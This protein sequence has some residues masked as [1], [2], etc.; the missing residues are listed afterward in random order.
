ME[1]KLNSRVD[2]EVSGEIYHSLVE[3]IKE[4]EI[5]LSMIHR[6]QKP[7]DL[8]VGTELNVVYSVDEVAYKFSSQVLRE[9]FGGHVPLLFIT[10]P[11]RIERHQRR[12]WVRMRT[13]LT[14]HCAAARLLQPEE[15]AP[16]LTGKIHDLSGGG[17]L[18]EVGTACQAGDQLL[19]TIHLPDGEVKCL[20][21]VRRI[22][23]DEGG[24]AYGI[25]FLLIGE[26]DRDRI[27][28]YIFQM[29]RDMRK[30]G[31]M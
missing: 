16:L 6:Q 18:L 28:R 5:V 19:L 27:I 29:Q 15:E 9:D 31:L 23:G 17:I 10:R 26:K 11:E 25:Q 4:R 1:L 12:E 3:D 21:E 13:T 14:V 30:K 2:V 24:H 7:V 8:P 22:L 20:G